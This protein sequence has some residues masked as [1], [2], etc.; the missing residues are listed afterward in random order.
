M[1]R[2]MRNEG[3]RKRERALQRHDSEEHFKNFKDVWD[4]YLTTDVVSNNAN[5][6]GV[7]ANVKQLS[8]GDCIVASQKCDTVSQTPTFT[9]TRT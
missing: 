5:I 6:K 2:G 7:N 8:K 4:T 1:D 3:K 9:D